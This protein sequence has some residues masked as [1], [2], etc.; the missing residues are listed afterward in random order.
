M[1]EDYSR[2]GQSLDRGRLKVQGRYNFLKFYSPPTNCGSLKTVGLG[3]AAPM[4]SP[5]YGDLFWCIKMTQ[6]QMFFLEHQ[7]V[8]YFFIYLSI[9]WNNRKKNKLVQ[10]SN[11]TQRWTNKIHSWKPTK[12]TCC[13]GCRQLVSYIW[14]SSFLQ[15]S[16]GNPST[17]TAYVLVET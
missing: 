13:C 11:Q 14:P 6:A 17:V 3:S 16:P 9:V 10:I 4:P 15:S 12:Q 8:V 1:E 7:W 5:S 2:S